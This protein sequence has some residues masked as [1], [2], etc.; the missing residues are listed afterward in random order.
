M[1]KDMMWLAARS[2][3]LE[4]VQWLRAEGCPWHPNT[5]YYA[6]DYGHVEVL[7]WVR[8]S[9]CPWNASVRNKAATELGYTDD[10][11]KLCVLADDFGKFVG[12]A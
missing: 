10:L 11:G 2:G 3:N 7:R 9:G 5:C 8:Q 4:L 12:N 6:V 1:D